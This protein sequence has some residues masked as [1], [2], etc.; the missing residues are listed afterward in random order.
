MNE[1]KENERSHF[2]EAQIETFQVAV[3]AKQRCPRVK[4]HKGK[5]GVPLA[6]EDTTVQ[7]GYAKATEGD[8]VSL[9]HSQYKSNWEEREAQGAK[10]GE[11]AEMGEP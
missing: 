1:V 6:P 8:V 3:R 9:R 5:R 10:Q 7:K 4:R 2:Y 11:T